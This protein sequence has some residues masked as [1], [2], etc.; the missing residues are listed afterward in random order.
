MKQKMKP[1]FP[2][3]MPENALRFFHPA[4]DE[5]FKAAHP[6]GYRLLITIGIVVLLLPLTIYGLIIVYF[7][8]AP[9]SG[10]VLL[11]IP[12]TFIIGIG[13]FNI[14]AAWMGQYL[15]HK[16]TIFCISIGFLIVLL[17]CLPMYSEFLYG[18]FDQ[19]LVWY[20]FINILFLALMLLY[21]PF[22]RSGM[23][24][25]FRDHKIRRT[26]KKDGVKWKNF[27]WYEDLHQQY[28]LGFLYHLNRLF[29][30]LYPLTF[31][32]HLFFGWIKIISIPVFI[33]FLLI[34]F[35]S[36]G[37]NLFSV[38]MSNKREYGRVFVLFV[39]SENGGFD[40][41]LFHLAAIFIPL[42][43]LYAETK[44]VTELWGLSFY[45]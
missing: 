33:L 23:Q 44:M 13:L 28:H 32:L 7:Y 14:V 38:I 20:Y 41:F 2:K 12:G 22:F 43:V 34:S 27:W 17:S 3:K 8:P 36:V 19:D 21:Y 37:M 24:D 30:V 45:F 10:W 42:I 39:R 18:I 29:V 4:S 11:G 15:G 5:A 25:W 35:L 9:D 6:W 16:V 26:E 1:A 31:C 40:C